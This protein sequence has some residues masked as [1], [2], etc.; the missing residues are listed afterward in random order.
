MSGN[1]SAALD[2]STIDVLRGYGLG[3]LG[4]AAIAIIDRVK[5]SKVHSPS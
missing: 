1:M 3:C 5:W 4:L 2:Y